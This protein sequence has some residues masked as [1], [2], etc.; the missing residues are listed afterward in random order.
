MLM[1]ILREV[2]EYIKTIIDII[3]IL[4]LLYGFIIAIVV[5]ARG[6]FS[7]TLEL[8][9]AV[10]EARVKMGRFILFGLEILIV[11]DIIHSIL[12]PGLEELYYLGLLVAIRTVIS[13]FLGK[14]IKEIEN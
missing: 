11:S 4:I 6:I 2:L 3:G 5:F 9:K 12:H 7:T 8:N 1:E 13:F 10:I 14:E